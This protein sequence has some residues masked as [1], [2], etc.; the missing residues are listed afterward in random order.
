MSSNENGK[1]IPLEAVLAGV[2]SAKDDPLKEDLVIASDPARL[3]AEADVN[4]LLAE[5]DSLVGNRSVTNNTAKPEQH[6][7]I[8]GAIGDSVIV[9]GDH[10]VHVVGGEVVGRDVLLSADNQVPVISQE[11]AFERIG[12][13]VR[14]NLSQLERNIEQARHE[15]NQFFKLTLIFSSVGFVIVL[16]GVVLLFAGQITAG[17][18][19]SIASIMPEVTA[20]LFFKKDQEL[21]RTIEAYHQ[22]M[23]D[24][25]QMLTMIDVAET[26]KNVDER[27]RMKQQII[28]KVLKITDPL[29]A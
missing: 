2:F 10:N 7:G 8:G 12:A 5:Y 14:L 13:A 16:I 24:S 23:L 17:V 11:Q 20:V 29:H 26:L 4:S 15:S 22:H 25:Q 3:Q 18:V 28:F 27:D 6:T 19:A 21:R 1:D 9:T